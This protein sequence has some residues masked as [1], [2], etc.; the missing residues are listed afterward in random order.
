L[1]VS[2]SGGKQ[3]RTRWAAQVDENNK[4]HFGRK[5]KQR[6]TFG[7]QENLYECANV[8]ELLTAA[9]EGTEWIKLAKDKAKGGA[10]I[11]MAIYTRILGGK[12]GNYFTRPA[13]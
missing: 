7:R 3:K 4:L 12:K 1:P 2:P 8:R 5:L 9:R 13:F 11:T 10:L 6:E